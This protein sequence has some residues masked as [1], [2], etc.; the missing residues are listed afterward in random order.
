MSDRCATAQGNPGAKRCECQYR[1]NVDVFEKE[2]EI[3]ILADLPG[4]TPDSI[5]VDYDDGELSIRAQVESR[6]RILRWHQDNSADA[7]RLLPNRRALRPI[8]AT[9]PP[10]GEPFAKP[11]QGRLGQVVHDTS[12]VALLASPGPTAR[13]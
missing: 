6:Y 7:A 4:A 13:H 12:V 10:R 5:E 2:D 1:P 9:T 8:P 11:P 3:V